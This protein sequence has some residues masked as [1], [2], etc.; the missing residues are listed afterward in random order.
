M[1]LFNSF[2]PDSGSIRSVKVYFS[3][4]GRQKLEEEEK[5]GPTGIWNEDEEQ[6]KDEENES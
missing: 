5:M 2:K 3:E 6:V 4:Y 1:I